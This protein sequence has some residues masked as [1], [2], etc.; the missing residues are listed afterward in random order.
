MRRGST[1]MQTRHRALIVFA[2]IAGAA[3]SA[4][5]SCSLV[6]RFDTCG[7][8]PDCI[9]TGAVGGGGSG[10]QV[11]PKCVPS[12]NSVPVE[13]SCG[14]FVASAGNDGDDGTPDAPVKTLAR[15]LELAGKA[16]RRVYACA[17]EFPEA[18][19]LPAGTLLYGGLDCKDG[20]RYVGATS[21]TTLAA[22]A[23]VIGMRFMAGAGTTHVEDV[24]VKAADAVAE[25]GSSIA[26]LAEE[27]V[28][29][30]LTRCELVAGNGKN[31]ADGQTPVDPIGPED[32]SHMSIV[33]V[34]GNAVCTGNTGTGNPGGPGKQNELCPTVPLSDGGTALVFG[35]TGG[36]G[37]VDAPESGEGGQPLPDSNPD[38][39]GLGGK[40]ETVTPCQ[41]GNN[42]LPGASGAPGPGASDVDLGAL[43]A[44]G[45]QG[46]DGQPGLQGMP[47]QG[48]GGGG[49]AKGKMN[50]NGASGGGGGAGGCGGNGGGGGKSGGASI[51]LVNLEASFVFA[52]VTLSAA[53]GGSGGNGG[54][55]QKGATGGLG[56]SGGKGAMT[57][58]ACN[59]GQGGQGG[60]GGMGGGGRGGHSVGI[61]YR[62]TAPSTDG[63]TIKPGTPGQGGLGADADGQG[64]PGRAEPTLAFP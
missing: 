1:L 64:A 22:P 42:G 12:E 10:G 47:G 62:G 36:K 2:L 52:K 50:C 32:P 3:A 35:G 18:V 17:E 14:V 13:A 54:N 57:L 51:A 16:D 5:S 60:P 25:G 38:G 24:D 6:A 30:A 15:A 58:D 11:D 29:V 49:G 53:S 27:G 46:A 61:A 31:G 9:A 48:G 4:A 26:A 23:D 21:K 44:S 56:G 37:S 19:E 59:G 7:L 28:S 43:N 39:F 34:N 41:E 45:L 8:D 33:G 55:G 63:A 40:G 20:W